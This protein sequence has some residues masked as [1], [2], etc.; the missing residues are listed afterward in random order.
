MEK[1]QTTKINGYEIKIHTFFDSNNSS[2]GDYNGVTKKIEYLKYL[3]INTL[4]INNILNYYQES[5]ELNFIH[6]RYGSIFDFNK[7]V[8]TLKQNEINTGPVIDFLELKQSYNNWQRAQSF[9]KE[10]N[11]SNVYLKNTTLQKYIAYDASYKNQEKEATDLLEYLDK[12]AAFYIKLN[13]SVLVF[14]NFDRYFSFS[15]SSA[16]NILYSKLHDFYMHIK[17]TYPNVS[18]VLRSKTLTY[19]ESQKILKLLNK[20]CDYIFVNKFSEYGLNKKYKNLIIAKF[21]YTHFIKD[22]K[23]YMDDD[24]YILSLSS[25]YVG[26]ICSRWGDELNFNYEAAKTFLL[27][28]ASAKNSYSIYYGDEL[29]T[30]KVKIKNTNDF[31]EDNINELKRLLQSKKIN[32]NTFLNSMHYLNKL[33]NNALM[34][35]SNEKFAGFTKNPVTKFNVSEKYHVNNVETEKTIH[36]SSLV[37][38][39]LYMNLLNEKDL[40]D[41][42]NANRVKIS[43][44]LARK[45]I[46]KIVKYYG[47]EKVIYL[48]N[49]TKQPR[50]VKISKRANILFSTY[51]NKIYTKL[52]N[53]LN[54]FESVIYTL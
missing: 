10:T 6:D 45:G 3:K 51:S 48:L 25:D 35:W 15:T 13:C 23:R 38:W 12:I 54:P 46:I 52:P 50:A 5:D 22:I 17:Q 32:N 27:V 37:F 43:K 42:F 40:F 53:T 7:M 8:N 21:D 41:L 44:H 36:N 33:S 24:R 31:N 28:I 49:L 14:D 16:K 19:S 18:I 9:Y 2:Y 20:I 4:F 1:L 34:S 47:G 39:N 30:L 26:R 29:A 11:N